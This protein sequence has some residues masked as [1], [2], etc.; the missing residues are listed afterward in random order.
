MR[1]NRQS[2]FTLAEQVLSL[3]VLA[4]V[5]GAIAT[6]VAYAESRSAD[7]MLERQGLA[8]AEAYLEEVLAKPYFDPDDGGVCPAPEAE[9]AQYDN[10]C[11]YAGIVVA[12]AVFPDGTATAGLED[13]EIRIEITADGSASLGPLTGFHGDGATP[14]AIRVDVSVR[15]QERVNLVLTGYRSAPPA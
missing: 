14:A 5:V 1:R 9:R 10:L 12:G 2:G 8:L 13:F 3:L 7:P 11:D 4:L 6:V 15:W